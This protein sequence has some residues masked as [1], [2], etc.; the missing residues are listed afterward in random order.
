MPE[1]NLP[2]SFPRDCASAFYQELFEMIPMAEQMFRSEAH[3]QSMFATA[4]SVIAKDANDL[5]HLNQQLRSLGRR[6]RDLGILPIHL[7]IGRQAFLNAVDRSVP[8]ISDKDR[9]FFENAFDA[10]AAT[11]MEPD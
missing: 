2:E 7:K 9:L 10:M 8:E 3:M 6:H 11:M 4:L 1:L 5:E